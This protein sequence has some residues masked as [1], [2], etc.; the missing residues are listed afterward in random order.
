MRPVGSILEIEPNIT[1]DDQTIDL[2]FVPELSWHTGDT[3]WAE[4]R[5]QF[6]NVLKVAEPDF[7]T[8]R[9]NTSIYSKNG[10]Y[11]LAGVLS[12]K[13]ATGEPDFTRKILV[14]VKCDILIV[15]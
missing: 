9:L 15:K 11:T 10:Q 14:F 6:G 12:P 13:D 8:L 1:V 2:R 5:D 7:Y 4:I 3:T